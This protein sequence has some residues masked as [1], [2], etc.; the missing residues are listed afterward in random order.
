MRRLL[1]LQGY[2]PDAIFTDRL[3]SCCAALRDLGLTDR[4]LTGG[5]RTTAGK[6]LTS[7]RA[8]GSASGADFD[9]RARRGGS[10]PRMPPS[11][12]TSTFN[13]I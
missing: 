1:K 2:L 10:L 11:T 7:R 8:G 4:H 6:S 12:T 5:G 13:A 9:H 3:R